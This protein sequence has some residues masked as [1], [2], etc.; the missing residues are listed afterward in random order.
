MPDVWGLAAIGAKFALYLGILTAAGTVITA[1]LFRLDHHKGFALKFALLGLIAT[2]LTFAL[3]GAVLTGDASGMSDPEIL[4]LLWST[5]VGTALALRIGGL[6][7]L[8]LGLFIARSGLWLSAFGGILAIWSFDHVGHVSGRDT[9]LLDIALTFHLIALAVWIGILTPLKRL[10]SAQETWPKAADVGHR[11]GVIASFTVPLLIVAGGYMG[12][13]L[14]GSTAALFGTGYGQALILKII[15]VAGFLMLGAANKMRFIPN[16][17]TDDPL[18][19]QHLSQS[20]T[21]E[22]LIVLVVLGTTATLTSV[23]TLPT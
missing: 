2:I 22:W 16:L 19:A 3:R 5:P 23:L 8:I 20:I 7:L 14:T 9:T 12:V 4:G 21:M 18:A 15:L 10:A 6:G 11:F 13:I 1:L 17:R